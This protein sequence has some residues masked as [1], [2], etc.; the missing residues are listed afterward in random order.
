MARNRGIECAH[1]DVLIFVDD[2]E[3]L[4][5]DYV[6]ELLKVYADHLAICGVSGVPTNYGRPPLSF[7][8]WYRLSHLGVFYDDR[9]PLSGRDTLSARVA[10]VSRFEAA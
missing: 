2:D 4:E 3:V 6:A 9:Q 5:P 10:H 8:A 1:G 7:R